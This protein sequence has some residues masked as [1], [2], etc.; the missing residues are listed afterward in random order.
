MRVKLL[1]KARKRYNIIRIDGMK[2]VTDKKYTDLYVDMFIVQDLRQGGHRG[3][4]YIDFDSA[5]QGLIGVIRHD[6]KKYKKK[7]KIPECTKVWYKG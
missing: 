5:H 1:K 2:D 4:L 6:Y 7:S 3:G